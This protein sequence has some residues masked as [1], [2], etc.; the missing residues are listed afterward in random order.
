MANI[1]S[2]FGIG[3]GGGFQHFEAVEAHAEVVSERRF[4]WIAGVERVDAGGLAGFS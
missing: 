4:G 1:A 3:S 2:K